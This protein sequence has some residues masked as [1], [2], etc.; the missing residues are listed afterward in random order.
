MSSSSILSLSC[1]K[2][3]NHGQGKR[4]FQIIFCSLF[5]VNCFYFDLFCVEIFETT[6]R[7]ENDSIVPRKVPEGV[8]L[9]ETNKKNNQPENKLARIENFLIIKH[10]S[11]YLPWFSSTSSTKLENAFVLSHLHFCFIFVRVRVE[12]RK[13]N[14]MKQ[15]SYC[16]VRKIGYYSSFFVAVNFEWNVYL[17]SSI[18]SNWDRQINSKIQENVK[19]IKI[20]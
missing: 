2:I 19:R 4:I 7:E 15:L 6:Q 10:F 9:P 12:K 5:H 17:V 18:H 11:L 20:D 14:K 1:T 8:A 13:I 16:V 3:L